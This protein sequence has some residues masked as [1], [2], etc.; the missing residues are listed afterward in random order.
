MKPEMFCRNTSGTLR[1]QHSSMKCA[2]FCAVSENRMPLLAMMPTGMPWIQAKP[3]TSVV[4]K[5]AFHSSSS[6][7]STMRAMT[8]RTSYGLRVSVGMTPYSSAGS[9]SGGRGS[10]SCSERR[11]GVV[12]GGEDAARQRQ[13]VGVVLRQ[14]I[15]HARQPRVHVAAAEVLGADDLARGRLHQRRAA[16][17]DRALVLDDDRLVAH[18]RHVGAAGGA[19]AHDDRDLR[20]ASAPTASPGCRRC[21]RSARDR[22]TPRP[23]WAGWRRPSR[24]GRRTAGG[25]RARF[26]ARAGAS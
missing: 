3:V 26:P 19:R 23:G 5:R 15:G 7:P 10:R 6:E 18:R 14:V 25:S 1:W 8:S 9:C 17:E 24:P 2:A 11:L 22:G 12:G 16:E 21:G 20:D 4:P 13:R